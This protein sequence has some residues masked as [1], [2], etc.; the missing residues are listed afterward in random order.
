MRVLAALF[1][2]PSSY[3]LCLGNA[4]FALLR[5]D[6]LSSLSGPPG[7]CGHNTRSTRRYERP[8]AGVPGLS[9]WGYAGSALYNALGRA[10]PIVL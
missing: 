8:L 7:V 9:G 4:A 10:F 3:L 1:C 5:P 2:L 6:A